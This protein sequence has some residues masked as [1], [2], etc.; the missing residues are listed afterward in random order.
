MN[1]SGVVGP[2]GGRDM[3]MLEQTFIEC[4]TTVRADRHEHDVHQTLVGDLT[5]EVA[6][7][8]DRPK[9]G[10][11]GMSFRTLAGRA[12]AERHVGILGVGQNEDV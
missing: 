4:E 3:R 10:F 7:F 12:D 2:D 11:T 5:H 8:F 9:P 6:I 1:I